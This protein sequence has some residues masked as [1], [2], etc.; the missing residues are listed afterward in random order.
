MPPGS[1][2][3]VVILTGAAMFTTNVKPAV[4]VVPLL[5]VARTPMLTG[6]AAVVGTPLKTPVRLKVSPG[7]KLVAVQATGRVPPCC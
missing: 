4:F 3:G 6:L 1:G 5:S 7:G 2:D